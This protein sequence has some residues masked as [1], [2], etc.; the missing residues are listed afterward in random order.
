MDILANLLPEPE[1]LVVNKVEIEEESKRII[2]TVS[3]NGATASCPVCKMVTM[4]LHS[5]YQRSLADLPWAGIPVRIHIEVHRFFCDNPCC[6][7]KIFSERLPGIAAPWARRTC[8]LAECQQAIGLA[9][10]GAGGTRLCTAL[11]MDGGIDLLLGLIRQCESPDRPTPQVLGVDDWAMCK[12]QTYGTIL[13]DLVQGH[14][15]DLLPDRSAET[16]T[17]WLQEHPGVE[18]VSRDRAGAYA[19][20]ARLGAPD[21]I[22]VADRWHLLKNLTEAVYKTLQQHHAAIE[23]MLQQSSS[24]AASQASPI[25]PDPASPD[26]VLTQP[27]TA[28]DVAR[29]QRVEA[30]HLLRQQ[31]WTQ[32]DIAQHLGLCTKTVRR[33]LNRALPMPPLRRSG[34]I[35]RIDPYRSYLLERWNAGCHNASQL[36]REIRAQGYTGQMT[37][38]RQFVSQLRRA[39]GLPPKVRRS[40]GE[41]V[42]IDPA[43]RPPTIRALAHLIVRPPDKLG[44]TEQEHLTKLAAVHPKLQVVIDLAREFAAMVRQHEVQPLEAWL[45]KATQ[46]H[47]RALH[48]FAAGLRQDMAAVR[49][50]LSMSWSNGPTE[51]HIN[52]LKCVKRQMYGRAKLDLLRQRLLAA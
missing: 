24:H 5:H 14:V 10:G 33:H 35:R 7:R 46:S 17:H 2:C 18:I 43:V 8:R 36:G 37:M 1:S 38:V 44:T 47:I 34:R 42:R 49:A 15:V 51:G 6:V 13:V 21:A 52:R 12:G 39:S 50:G 45:Q 40:S 32:K 9:T 19:E 41:S 4:R 23:Q 11:A 29:Q 30:V 31:D 26:E 27:P 48:S 20:G 3:V 25:V 22:Q 28:A 16:L